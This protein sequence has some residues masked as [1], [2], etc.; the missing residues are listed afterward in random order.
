[1]SISAKHMYDRVSPE[2][3]DGDAYF[4][5]YYAH[6]VINYGMGDNGEISGDGYANF[7][8]AAANWERVYTAPNAANGFQGSLLMSNLAAFN[9]TPTAVWPRVL[10][11][12]IRHTNASRGIIWYRPAIEPIPLLQPDI[13]LNIAIGGLQII[14]RD[15]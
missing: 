3:V 7:N 4:G 11:L 13:P 5:L 2:F 15:I 6:P 10:Y 8:L 9:F 14:H 1:M 12:A